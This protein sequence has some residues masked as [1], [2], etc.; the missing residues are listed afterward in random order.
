MQTMTNAVMAVAHN[1]SSS[2]VYA[3]E[4]DYVLSNTLI[5]KGFPR[6]RLGKERTKQILKEPCTGKRRFCYTG[7]RLWK[8]D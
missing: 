7:Y 8:E 4:F 3:K 5:N 1:V 6:Y 2:N